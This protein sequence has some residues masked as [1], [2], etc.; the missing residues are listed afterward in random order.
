[1]ELLNK[2]PKGFFTTPSKISKPSNNPDDEIIPVKWKKNKKNKKIIVDSTN[3][4]KC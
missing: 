3:T 2:F 1:M 4:S